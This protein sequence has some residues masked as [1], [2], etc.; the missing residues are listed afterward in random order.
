MAK[1][2]VDTSELKEELH[3]SFCFLA[4]LN[5]QETKHKTP[6]EWKECFESSETVSN[7]WKNWYIGFGIGMYKIVMSAVMPE[8]AYKQGLY[9]LKEVNESNDYN[10]ILDITSDTIEYLYYAVKDRGLCWKL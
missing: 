6:H 9:N 1:L 4:D 10:Y 7:V 8:G 2:I 5:P 3:R